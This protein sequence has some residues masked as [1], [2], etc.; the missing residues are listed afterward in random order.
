MIAYR[1]TCGYVAAS[2]GE[3]G[4]HWGE[5]FIP[6]DDRDVAGVLHAEAASDGADRDGAVGAPGA[7][8]RR[9]V[10]CL[11]GDAFGH[12]G[13]LDDHLLAAFMPA[14]RTGLDGRGHRPAA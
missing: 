1:C 13:E 4:D 12:L 10:A 14:D 3:L 5:A 2:G 9:A 8:G 6:P 11:C 7:D